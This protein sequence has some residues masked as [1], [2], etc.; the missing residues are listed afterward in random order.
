[1]IDAD[2]TITAL[3]EHPERVALLSDFDGSLST[4]V[5]WADDAQALP[6][7]IAVLARLVPKLG[8]VGIISGRPIDFLATQLPIPGLALAGL[9]GF[10]RFL[11]GEHVVDARA[12]PYVDAVAAARSELREKVDGALVEDKAGLSVTVHWR[13]RPDRAAELCAL[14]EQIAREHGLATLRTR[15]ALELRPPIAIDKGD[16]TRALIEG[17][18]VA[19]FAGDDSGDLPAF[20]ALADAHARGAL[21]TAIRIGVHSPEAPP[22]LVESTDIMVDGP[23]GLV[24]LLA[25]VADQIA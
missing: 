1:V 21:H 5:E 12:V 20:A 19:A 23:R 2:A 10:E 17:F 7:A 18:D 6:E 9:Y 8:R 4:I 3:S 24:A 25:R 13:P 15:M 11:D 22:E 14:G 16:R